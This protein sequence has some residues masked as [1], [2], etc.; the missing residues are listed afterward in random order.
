MGVAEV[1]H[2]V[3]TSWDRVF[4]WTRD[5]VEFAVG[6]AHAADKILD[7]CDVFLVRFRGK[8]NHGTPWPLAFRD[9]SA[10]QEVAYVRHDHRQLV[11]AV[12]WPVAA[13]RLGTHLC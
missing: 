12:P 8:D 13:D 3:V 4:E 5:R 1:F 9:P 7:A 10:I 11:D 2:C 6:D